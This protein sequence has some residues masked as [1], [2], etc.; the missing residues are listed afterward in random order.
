VRRAGGGSG[1]GGSGSAPGAP[2]TDIASPH[3]AASPG[4]APAKPEPLGA[5]RDT[6]GMSDGGGGGGGGGGGLLWS[7]G[8]AA[9]LAAVSAAFAL[10]AGVVY[11]YYGAGR[12]DGVGGV[13]V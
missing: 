10:G 5:P 11:K 12:G 6:A 1:G 7:L 3:R 13:G 8:G 2:S 4:P 9:E